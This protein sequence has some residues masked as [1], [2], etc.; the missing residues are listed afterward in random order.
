MPAA[1]CPYCGDQ[2]MP[3]RRYAAHLRRAATCMH[4]GRTVHVRGY[5]AG[6]A[7]AVLL[8]AVVIAYFALDEHSFA[9]SLVV[10]GTFGLLSFALDYMFWRRLG[11]VPAG[12]TADPVDTPDIGRP[13]SL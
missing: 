13:T 8:A 10:L 12:E 3:Y 9:E 4:C 1:S 6:L 11:F 7:G 2:V 5:Y